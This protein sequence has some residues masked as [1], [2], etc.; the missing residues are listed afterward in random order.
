MIPF[1]P[2]HIATKGIKI[3]LISLILVSVV[4]FRFAMGIEYTLLG[5]IW[6]VGFFS[7]SSTATTRWAKMP[8]KKFCSTV[9]WIAFTIRVIWVIFS[10]FFYS[11]KTGQ[12]FEFGAA[13]SIG[14]HHE[15]LEFVEKGWE[16]AFEYWKKKGAYSDVG[17]PFWLLVLYN[18][19]GPSIIITRLFKCVFSSLSC[20]LIYKLARRNIDELP[21]RMAAIFCVFMPNLIYYCGLHLKETEMLFLVCLYLERADDLLRCKRIPFFKIGYVLLLAASLFFFRTVLGSVLIISLFAGLIF[22]PESII[23]RGRKIWISL[24]VVVSITVFA[25]GIIS[26]EIEGYWAGRNTNTEMQR[27]AQTDRGN[28]W[29]HYATG[30]VMSPMAF[31][32]PFSTMIHIEGQEDQMILSGG[33]F[34][35]NY[36]GVFF[37]IALYYSFIKMKRW[38]SL[39]LIWT[40]LIGYLL[41]VA[42]SGFSN[43]ER[44][45]LPALPILLII[46]AYGVSH[47]NSSNYKYVNSWGIVVALMEVGWAIFKIGSRGLL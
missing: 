39:S 2:K 46:A 13:D 15:A 11:A 17:Y 8:P 28:L 43:S 31:V 38:R 9:F 47:I 16:K 35:R 44:F 25:G 41:V 40:Y 27:R 36:F 7:I 32:L 6:V 18:V 33:N 24:W 42:N 22:S 29:A 45:L 1:F 21:G 20:V 14:Y 3:Y 5:L 37:L 30:V 23:R 12:P 19:F 4:F 34:I 10:Y 26:T